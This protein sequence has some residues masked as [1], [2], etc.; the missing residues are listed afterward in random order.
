MAV[1]NS[2][3]KLFGKS[4]ISPLQAHMQTAHAAVSK[5]GMLVAA[6]QADD[7][8]QANTIQKDVAKLCAEADRMKLALRMQMRKSLF[9]PVSRSDLLELLTSQDLIADYGDSFANLLISRRMQVP[10]AILPAFEAYLAEII[11]VADLALDAVNEL[12]EVLEVGFGAHEIEL[13]HKKL[14]GLMRRENAARKME[15]KLRHRL[16]KLERELDPLD[17]MF[18]YKLVEQLD[19]IGRG[20]ERIGNRLLILISI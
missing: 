4:P 14:Q 2:L 7:W 5:L 17:A 1:G 11:S 15:S 6:A 19:L 8:K 3:G 12:D 10:E 13:V 16:Y 9:M 20:S 18:L